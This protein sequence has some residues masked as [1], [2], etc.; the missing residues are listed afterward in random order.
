M[1]K[2]RGIASGFFGVRNHYFSSWQWGEKPLVVRSIWPGMP[3]FSN[4]LFPQREAK[5]QYSQ[6]CTIS[7][8]SKGT[9]GLKISSSREVKY[10]RNS[11]S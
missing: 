3:P 1:G 9:F 2:A 8:W 6:W 5:S 4:Y 11:G 7:V 10:W